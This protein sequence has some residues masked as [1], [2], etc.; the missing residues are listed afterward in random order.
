MTFIN[1]EGESVTLAAAESF[2]NDFKR[3]T[4]EEICL[5]LQDLGKIEVITIDRDDSNDRESW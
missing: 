2:M 4:R 1:D 5:D 3:N